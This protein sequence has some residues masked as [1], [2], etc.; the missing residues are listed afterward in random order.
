MVKYVIF[1]PLETQNLIFL[2]LQGLSQGL[3]FIKNKFQFFV[4]LWKH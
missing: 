3:I 1:V 2:K 4:I